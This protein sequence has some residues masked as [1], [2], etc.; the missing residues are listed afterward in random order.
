MTR[1]TLSNRVRYWFDN[2]MSKGPIA[3][4]GL[5]FALSALLIL[6]ISFLVTL[7][8]LDRLEDGSRLGFI[9]IA[10][11]S[12]MRTLDAGTMGGDTGSWPFLIAMFIV[13]L[14]GVFIVSTL[15][16]VLSSG[17]E[18]KI[19]ELRKGRSF[20]VEEGHIVIL[21]WSTQVFSVVSELVIANANQKRACIAILADKDKIEMEDEIK[22]RVPGLKTTRLV[23]RTG[24]TIDLADLEIVNPH[25]SRAI[26]ILAPETEDADTHTIKTI[27]AITNSP[28]RR[29]EPYHITA[30]IRDPDNL[31]AA[32]LVGKDEVE[33]IRVD[34]LISRITAQTCRQ[35]GLSVVYT[36]LFDFGGD[37]IYFKEEPSLVGKSFGEALLAYETSSLM[38]LQYK[39]RRV[40]LLPPMETRIQTG[41]R[42][43]VVSADDDTILLSGLSDL[44]I[45]NDLIRNKV[46]AEPG[47]EN[48]LILGWNRRAPSIVKELDNYV[49]PGS[50][51]LIVSQNDEMQAR[52]NCDCDALQNQTVTFETGDSTKRRVLDSLNLLSFDHIIS[53]SASDLHDA[54]QADARSM[55]TLLHL[56]D[57]AD[58]HGH[59]FSIVSEMLDVR[60]RELAEVC[61]ADDFIVSDKLVSLMMS[62]IA[63]NK[64]LAPVFEDLFDPEG[65]EL[66]LKPCD[67]YIELGKPVNFYTI[68]EAARQRG[69]I[70]IGY[71]LKSESAIPDASYGVHVNPVKSLSITFTT[72]DKIIT[73]AEN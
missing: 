10:W 4:I 46:N 14:G 66:Y 27:L 35:S 61:R 37:E 48:T 34:E 3:M 58:Q 29:K 73:L 39:D 50:Q 65:A 1:I 20:V 18:G 71:R 23:C 69:E 38:G 56:R 45:D 55:I 60:N 5:L 42:I 32:R 7:L 57:I 6:I 52:I 19:D 62:Q 2:T 11:M 47:P 68:V 30:E 13:T 31:E 49:A 64:Y 72:E 9:Q 54:Q 67:N 25:A 51:V 33:L 41:D 17:I 40:Q 21:G 12:L 63:E 22:A 44:Q 43:I 24:S 70:A 59:P 16:G 8:G 26:I 15:I 36:E 53:L 28:K